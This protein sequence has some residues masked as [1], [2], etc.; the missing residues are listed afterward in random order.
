MISPEQENRLLEG[1]QYVIRS[2]AAEDMEIM[3][4]GHRRLGNFSQY[5]LY[6][7]RAADHRAWCE[8]YVKRQ[9]KST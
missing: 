3:A 4:K 1:F 5:E 2:L 6:M 8:S 7:K 9:E